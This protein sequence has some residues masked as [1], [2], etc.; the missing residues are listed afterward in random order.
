MTTHAPSLGYL[1]QRVE[2]SLRFVRERF[3]STNSFSDAPLFNAAMEV[4]ETNALGGKHIRP[5]LV[6]IAAGDCDGQ[7][8][9][10]AVVFGAAVELLHAAL[11]V[12]DDVIDND[13]LR[14]G[15]ATLH[16]RVVAEGGD[17]HVG[18][19]AAILAGDMGLIAVFETLTSAVPDAATAQ[20]ACA[21][22]ASVAA[23]TIHGELLD[24]SHKLHDDATLETVRASNFFKTSLY[25]FTAPLHL[26]ALAAGRADAET[27]DALT[28]VANPL[29]RAYQ[30][31]DDIA[32]VVGHAADTG[33]VAGGDLHE[34]RRTL[35]TLRLKSM[36]LDQAVAAVAAEAR[37]Q[38]AAASVAAGNRLL[39]PV[40]QAG[41]RAVIAKV[42]SSLNAYE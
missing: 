26:G 19:A 3:A 34:D 39:T 8:R 40:T 4:L 10:S 5:R 28:A 23:Q 37:E 41:L 21:M 9:E 38:I 20:R 31:A 33:K 14:R 27:L 24:V 29:G 25:T 2:E 22:V 13:P 30:A 6:H 32:G 16:E 17:R 15:K 36:P 35:L 42:E 11:L 18:M 7:A 12:H 1:D